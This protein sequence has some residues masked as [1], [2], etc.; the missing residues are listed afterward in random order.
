MPL[1]KKACGA[2]WTLSSVDDMVVFLVFVLSAHKDMFTART[3]ILTCF[4][5]SVLSA[6]DQKHGVQNNDS[7]QE[8]TFT[9][10]SVPIVGTAVY[11]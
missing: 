5:P 7:R 4:S 2:I 1:E 10:R 9:I 11:I 3:Y 6:F 8:F